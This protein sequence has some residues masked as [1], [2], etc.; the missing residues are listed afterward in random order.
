M[1]YKYTIVI[2]GEGTQKRDVQ[3]QGVTPDSMLWR[4]EQ[5]EETVRVRQR[6]AWLTAD[7]FIPSAH[8][9]FHCL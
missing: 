4:G 6:Y 1:F 7:M 5:G 8:S 3:Q 9:G 2:R